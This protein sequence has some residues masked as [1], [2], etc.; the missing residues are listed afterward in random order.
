MLCSNNSSPVVATIRNS[1]RPYAKIS[2]ISD[3][4]DRGMT[5]EQVE[6]AAHLEFGT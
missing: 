5:S 3:L 2:K 6:K 4:M 1:R